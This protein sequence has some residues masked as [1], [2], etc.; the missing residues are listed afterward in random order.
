M[1]LRFLKK[2]L[3]SSLS[4]ILCICLFFGLKV[5]AAY[6]DNAGAR[7]NV[8][9]DSCLVFF[10][11][12]IDLYPYDNN[13]GSFDL[14]RDYNNSSVLSLSY[15][16]SI[17]DN[18]LKS[19]YY[20]ANNDNTKPMD[21]SKIYCLRFDNGINHYIIYEMQINKYLK[22]EQY[23][24]SDDISC[25]ELFTISRPTETVP[26]FSI[27]ASGIIQRIDINSNDPES[28]IINL[29]VKCLNQNPYIYMSRISRNHGY[30]E[31]YTKGYNEGYDDGQ[32]GKTVLN[33]VWDMLSG[34]FATVGTIMSIELF[35]N[36]PIGLFFFV[37]LFFAVVGLIL[38]I[39][40]RN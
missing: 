31:G 7:I 1:K 16:Y 14:I 37:P 8:D 35:P 40:R 38:W 24:S 27:I 12:P 13:T 17:T 21:T 19:T 25:I 29:F 39:W 26:F 10:Q 30:N 18:G 34:L 9:N 3:F 28:T 2:L 15:R 11:L 4:I 23:Y 32:E 36:V 33:N 6:F 22:N 20:Y 5:N